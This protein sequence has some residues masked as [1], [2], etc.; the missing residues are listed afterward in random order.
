[1]KKHT[2]KTATIRTLEQL[3]LSENEAV[4]YSL[5]L[6]LPHCSVQELCVRAPF[7][8][9][10]LYYVLKQLITRGL[11]VAKREKSKTVYSAENPEHLYRLLEQKSKTFEQESLAIKTLIP[12]LKRT[13][14]LK[15]N[16][17]SVRTFDG[18]GEYQKA[19]DDIIVSKPKE[20]LAYDQFLAK[21]PGHEVF[22]VHER[23]RISRKIKKRILFF[24]NTSTLSQVAKRSYDDFSVFRSIADSSVAPFSTNVMLYDGK[25]LYTS[26]Y[27]THEPTAILI[28][29]HAL[30]V[31]QKNIFESLWKRGTD[32]TITLKTIK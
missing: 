25:I 20:V 6:T 26:Y 4:L 28:E 1:M 23:T 19:L 8:R 22:A 30:Y 21:K 29:D 12:Q 13:F 15:G 27:D 24:A 3:H 10:M 7:P 2:T 18:V 14:R 16:R 31:M 32:R 17:P 9:T 11:V 5:M